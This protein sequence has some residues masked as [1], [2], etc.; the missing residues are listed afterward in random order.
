M[1]LAQRIIEK[2]TVLSNIQRQFLLLV[3]R[4]ILC[5]RSRVNFATMARVSDWN[6]RT[7]RRH[8]G[9]R[10]DFLPLHRS[11]IDTVFATPAVGKR[12]L[13]FDPS[14]I[15]KAGRHTPGLSKFWN[16]C[17]QRAENGLE[18][19]ISAIV[20][21]TTHRALTLAIEQTKVAKKPEVKDSEETTDTKVESST[22]AKIET[23]TD[24]KTEAEKTLIDEYL[25]HIQAIEP[26]LLPCERLVVVDCYF[27]KKCFLNGLIPLKL[28][29]VTKL[30]TDANMQYYYTGKKREGRGRQKLY[31]GKVQWNSPRQEV[32]ERTV[33]EDGTILL[34]AVLYHVGLKRRLRVVIVQ[35]ASAKKKRPRN[36]ILASTD[37]RLDATTI[38]QA[39]RARFQ[40]EFLIRDGKGF[41]GLTDAQTRNP[42]ALDTHWNLSMLTLNLARA[43]HY[44]GE[45]AD[46][47]FSM[48]S[49]KTRTFNEHFAKRILSIYG[50][51]PEMINNHPEFHNISNYAVA[52]A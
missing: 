51:A 44:L 1:L 38:Y 29:C 19:T 4:T 13:I 39:Y 9:Q 34:T 8:F 50:I 5:C 33:L 6:E 7:F 18:V 17:A 2:N 11:V 46:K 45:N 42:N 3:I 27:A 41:T 52:N 20:E 35:N 22:E 43:E 31:D 37:E 49:I 30:R 14:F 28:E 32:F 21:L 12:A 23:K 24:T 36:F 40:V 48:D 16:G 15:P 26:H 25:R 10:I 47:P